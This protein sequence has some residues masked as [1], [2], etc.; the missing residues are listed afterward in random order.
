MKIMGKPTLRVITSHSELA[1]LHEE[2]NALLERS[3]SDTVFLTWEWMYTWWE[4]FSENK[5]LFVIVAE[6]EGAIIGIAPLHITRS[7]YFGLRTLRHIEF[8]GTSGV[9]TEYLDFIIQ[10]GQ[11]QELV[12]A[13]LNFLFKNS[14]EWDA[15]NLVSMK[16]DALNLQ[17]IKEYCKEKGLQ[18]WEYASRIAPYIE[19]PASMDEYMQ[20]L[21]NNSRWRFRKQRKTLENG[22][23]VELLETKDK[24]AVAPDFTT[25]MQLHQKRWEQKGGPG[26]FAEERVGFLKFHKTIVQRFF[27]NGWLYLLRLLVDGIPTAGHYNYFYHNKVYYHSIGFDPEW[28]EYNVGSVLQLLAVE[29]SIGKG[30]KEFDF[31]SGNEPY[32]YSWTK[33]DRTSVDTAVWRSQRIEHRVDVERKLRKA[34]KVLFPKTIVEKIFRRIVNRD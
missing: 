34:A 7:R 23:N 20:S 31:L 5:K 4:C 2:W 17:L 8:L 19:L 16:Q 30:A 10:K 11:E 6:D 22:R 33:K 28:A 14:S 9:I 25:I 26:S 27:D 13:L 3:V 24:K 18:S 32:K 12:P 29:D 21:S 1:T 15:L